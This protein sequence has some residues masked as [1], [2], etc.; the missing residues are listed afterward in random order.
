MD[1]DVDLWRDEG[2][3][4]AGHH[5]QSQD[6]RQLCVAVKTHNYIIDCII[7]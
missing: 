6:I 2:A 3:G 7:L 4:Q 5:R 1:F